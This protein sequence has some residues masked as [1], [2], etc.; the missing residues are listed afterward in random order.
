MSSR[1]SLRRP[2]IGSLLGMIALNG[3]LSAIVLKV[4]FR[5]FGVGDVIGAHLAASAGT[6]VAVKWDHFWPM[7]PGAAVGFGCLWYWLIFAGRSKGVNW[8]VATCY[9]VGVA[10][11]NVPLSG[12]IAG[13]LHGD[14]FIG[15]LMA[16]LLLMLLPSLM[17]S[18][19]C[20]GLTLGCLNGSMAQ[21]WIVQRKG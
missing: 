3:V 6:Q 2:G 13:F 1:R 17:V 19:L 11:G 16:L 10:C 14:P 8:G 7:L 12:L 4:L 9:G 21:R 5:V 15:F 18:T 20:F